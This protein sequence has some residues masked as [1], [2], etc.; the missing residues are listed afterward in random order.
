MKKLKRVVEMYIGTG[1]DKGTWRTDYVEILRDTPEQDIEKASIVQARIDFTSEV[2]FVFLGLYN[3][4]SLDDSDEIMGYTVLAVEEGE[5]FQEYVYVTGK[6][7]PAHTEIGVEF[8]N[9]EGED[10]VILFPGIFYAN[11]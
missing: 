8:I 9:E 2:D 5:E 11:N 4:P 6:P 10:E 7:V 1:T 3:I